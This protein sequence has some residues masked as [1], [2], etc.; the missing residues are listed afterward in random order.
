[1]N[2]FRNKALNEPRNPAA[3][4]KWIGQIWQYRELI[5]MLVIRDLKV[6][7][8]RSVLG[9]LWTLLN[10]LITILIFAM[11]FSRVFAA[12]YEQYKLYMIS[13]VLIWNFFSLT[14]SQALTSVVANG[15]TLRKMAVP[16]VVFPVSVASSNFLNLLFS[17][18]ALAVAFPFVGGKPSVALLWVPFVLPLLFLFTLGLGFILST[19]TVFVRDLRSMWEPLLMIWFFLTPVFYPRTVIPRRFYTVLRLN[20]MLSILEACRVPLYASVSPSV[21]LL[22]KSAIAAVLAFVIGLWFFNRCE[23]KF[24]YY[25]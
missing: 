11:V 1:M 12:F 24:V 15:A 9:F 16:K 17:F 25:V 23:D 19:L 20:P 13:G 21:G 3:H 22:T 5:K 6:R 14:T 18:G 2:D 8:K 10:P 7:Y 4:L